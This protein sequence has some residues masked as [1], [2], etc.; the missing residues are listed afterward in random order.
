[1]GEITPFFRIVEARSQRELTVETFLSTKRD[2]NIKRRCHEVEEFSDFLYLHGFLTLINST[3]DL[4][5]DSIDTLTRIDRV[6]RMSFTAPDPDQ[7]KC[8]TDRPVYTV[9]D[10]FWRI[11]KSRDELISCLR[12]RISCEIR[13][14]SL[15][16]LR[17]NPSLR[18]AIDRLL[19]AEL[20]EYDVELWDDRAENLILLFTADDAIEEDRSVWMGCEKNFENR[21]YVF[22]FYQLS[23]FDNRLYLISHL[24]SSFCFSAKLFSCLEENI[25]WKC[26]E[27]FSCLRSFST[28]LDTDEHEVFHSFFSEIKSSF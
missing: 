12:I 5:K 6:D 24:C 17:I 4:L 21:S 25:F 19:F 18:E 3:L 1:M 11:I 14:K 9:S 7:R 10:I 13:S 16:R 20:E 26:F 22:C 15:I 28:S 8:V 27:D 2:V 23:C